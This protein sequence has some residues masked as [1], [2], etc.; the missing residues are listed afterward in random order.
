MRIAA[1]D[2]ALESAAHQSSYKEVREHLTEGYVRQGDAFNK[3]NLVAGSHRESIER[4]SLTEVKEE[5]A[6]YSDIRQMIAKQDAGK[7]T[8]DQ[9]MTKSTGVSN[10]LLELTPE[11]KLK[12]EMLIRLFESLT[13]KRFN[14]GM[15][16]T[17]AVGG[18]SNSNTESLSG[19]SSEL[20]I[21]S[22]EGP[23]EHGF[24]YSYSETTV[25]Q[26]QV[27]F[28]ATGQVR[29]ADGKVIDLNLQLNMSRSTSENRSLMIRMGAAL[30]DPLV[31]NFGG[32]AA[33]LSSDTLEFDI[34]SDGDQELIHRLAESSGYI[35]LDKNA[36][37]EVDDGSEL[38][39][40]TSGNGFK[41]LAEYDDDKNGF[42]DEGDAIWEKLQ[43]WVQHSDGSSSMFSLAEKGVGALY[44]GYTRTDWDL[45]AG[46]NSQN[47]GGKIR[48]TGLFLTE[49][50]QTGTLQQVDLV[51]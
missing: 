11:D 16:N 30:K 22:V 43:I 26:E 20:T 41:E 34:D 25:K 10:S 51:V 35:A 6:T 37:G 12:I 32:K 49:E 4:E 46:E 23:L 7:Y 5:K 42:I 21:S 50:G 2:I 8:L 40:A 38:F 33:E 39:G 29:T 19:D 18:S 17:P 48:A 3:D 1:S 9:L 36:N 47:L 27:Q 13:G 44:L 14:V 45:E 15:M 24:E 28:Q 31:I